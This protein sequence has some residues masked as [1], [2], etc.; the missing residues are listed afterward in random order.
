MK[1]TGAQMKYRKRGAPVDS[2]FF[3]QRVEI[4]AEGCWRWLGNTVA[5][6]GTVKVARRV[7]KAHRL[8]YEVHV[9]A[10]N[11]LCVCHRCDVPSCVNPEH[12]FLGDHAENMRDMI[13]KGRHVAAWTKQPYN[14]ERSRGADGK[15]VKGAR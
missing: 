8:S 11:G 14:M 13:R 1:V 3:R 4:T 6:Y 7:V 5:G 9:G 12:L 10:T 2:D 15:F